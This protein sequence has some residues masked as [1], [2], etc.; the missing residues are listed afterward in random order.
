MT[1]GYVKADRAVWERAIADLRW[2]EA[3]SSKIEGTGE[4]SYE[5]I[6]KRYDHAKDTVLA[7]PAPDIGA[8]IAKMFLLFAEEIG[9]DHTIYAAHKIV[10]G[11]LR[12]L[13]ATAA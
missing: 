10:I 8:V 9:S 1:D 5:A 11:D 12:R 2:A 6:A 7:Q 3:A 13:S 4:G